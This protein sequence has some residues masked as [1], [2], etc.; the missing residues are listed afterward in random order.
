L[1]WLNTPNEHCTESGSPI[2]ILAFHKV[3]P[4]WDWSVTRIPPS[5]FRS[6]LNHLVSLGKRVVPLE[7]VCG[8]VRPLDHDSVALTFDDGYEC[9]YRHAFPI[10]GS[11]GITAAVFLVTG[12]MGRTN[13]WD[14]RLAGN[15]TRHLSWAQVREMG[16]A[17]LEIGSHTVAHSDLTRIKPKD[18]FYEIDASKKA[19]EDRIGRPV[20]FFAFPFGRYNDRILDFCRSAGYAGACAYWIRK[21]D[22][23]SKE[24]FVFERKPVYLIHQTGDLKR[25]TGSG[26]RFSL[27]DMRDRIVNGFSL[28]TPLVKKTVFPC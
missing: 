12:F 28:G 6:V 10:L 4:E 23:Q 16:D 17:G 15:A 13:S 19:I 8:S 21:N 1:V 27:G 5:R 24:P 9:M 22:R 18:A 20:R 25:A 11:M 3:D 2:P 26:H 14:I 7:T